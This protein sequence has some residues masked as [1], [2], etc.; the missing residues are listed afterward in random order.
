MSQTIVNGNDAILYVSQ[1]DGTTWK[2]MMLASGY[3]LKSTLA[4]RTVASQES[5]DWE[6]F[7][8]DILSWSVSLSGTVGYGTSTTTIDKFAVFKQYISKENVM[9]K[10]GLRGTDYYT[11]NDDE[12]YMKGN[13]LIV[14]YDEDGQRG[15]SRSYSI[16]FQGNG[17]LELVDPKAGA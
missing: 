13:A 1:D 3:S 12:G 5:G 16:E 4:T 15:D 2:P 11:A 8:G 6:E 9:L 17:K 7:V 10:L 14:N